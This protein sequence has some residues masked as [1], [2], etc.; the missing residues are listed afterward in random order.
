MFNSDAQQGEEQGRLVES[1]VEDKL[2]GFV[3]L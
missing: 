3:E 2:T 1:E